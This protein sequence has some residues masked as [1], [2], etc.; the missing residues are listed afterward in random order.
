MDY[1]I[2]GGNYVTG[3][4]FPPAGERYPGLLPHD[5]AHSLL[6]R[7]QGSHV[8][9][10]LP[11]RRDRARSLRIG[12]RQPPADRHVSSM[13]QISQRRRARSV[14]DRDDPEH[15]A[16]HADRHRSERT[17]CADPPRRRPRLR[18][19]PILATGRANGSDRRSDRGVEPRCRR[20]A[21]GGEVAGAE[22]G[23]F[24]RR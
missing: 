7:A 17:R 23:R 14:H 1:A 6:S 9:P 10:P 12:V 20:L 15:V 16:R 13:D 2:G 24:P 3:R 5:A 18:T 22:A 8:P 4:M 21:G 11:T 19:R